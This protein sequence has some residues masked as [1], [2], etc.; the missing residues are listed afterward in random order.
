[1]TLTNTALS[2]MLF[3][4]GCLVLFVFFV[5]V[6]CIPSEGWIPLENCDRLPTSIL[7]SKIRTCESS[8]YFLLRFLFSSN[9]YSEIQ[10]IYPI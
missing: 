10:A 5:L 2:N 9:C 7:T 3:L 4:V 6:I 8:E 1:M